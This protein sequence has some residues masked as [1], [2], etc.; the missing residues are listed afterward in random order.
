MK[1][2]IETAHVRSNQR[3]GKIFIGIQTQS[4]LRI[5]FVKIKDTSDCLIVILIRFK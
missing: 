1:K 4:G 2:L 3:S 5:T